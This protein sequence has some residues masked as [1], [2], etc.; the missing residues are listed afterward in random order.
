MWLQ[1]GE[2]TSNEISDFKKDAVEQWRNKYKSSYREVA[3][4]KDYNNTALKILDSIR[5]KKL[6][7]CQQ[8][9][10]TK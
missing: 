2:I 7:I 8:P 6:I 5:E 9:M 1:Q 4:E 3:D 10:D